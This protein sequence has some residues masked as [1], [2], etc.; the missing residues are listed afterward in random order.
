MTKTLFIFE[1][2]KGF[3]ISTEN[4]ILILLTGIVFLIGYLNTTPYFEFGNWVIY[5]TI[6]WFLYF[7]GYGISNFFLQQRK[8]GEFKGKLELEIN[9]IKING[10]KYEL[11]EISKISIR[12][13]D[14]EGQF[15]STQFAFA[16]HSSNGLNNELIIKLV[17]GKEIK[18]HFLQTT[19]QR[20]KNF[21]DHLTDYHLKGKMSWLHLLEVLEME[22]YNEIQIFKKELNQRK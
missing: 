17:N 14:F 18:C 20:I 9:S 8:N 2:K 11:N 16:R 12:A 15:F 10:T 21:K 5:F 19:G 6:I 1:H 22:D 3:F 4:L 13:S 7:V